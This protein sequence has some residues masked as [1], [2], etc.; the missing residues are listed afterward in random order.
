MIQAT[1]GPDDFAGHARRALLASGLAP[2]QGS[3]VSVVFFD[4]TAW[5]A[6]ETAAAGLLDPGERS[7]AA[8]FRFDRDRHAYVLAHALWR[9]VLAVCLERNPDGVPLRFLPSGQPNLP[10]TPLATSLS[11]S[12]PDVLVAVGATRLLGVDLERWP[13]RASM[14]GLLPAICTP[15]EAQAM[16]ALPPAQRERALLQLWTRKEAVLKAFGTGLAQA[17]AAF[18][19]VPGEPVVPPSNSGEPPC[20]AFDLALP[21]DRLGSL[22][23][24]LETVRYRLYLPSGAGRAAGADG[25]GGSGPGR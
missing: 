21:G 22:A 9:V 20:R 16:H 5:S 11:H 19:V 18:G 3:D 14:D 23:T 1:A 25:F 7:R 17:P 4:T 15:E 6:F 12:G 13:P 2:R 8:R 24:S 10:G